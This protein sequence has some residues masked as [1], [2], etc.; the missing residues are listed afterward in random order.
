VLFLIQ[1]NSSNPYTSM[2][3][4]SIVPG[5]L[6]IVNYR[7]R[8]NAKC[9]SVGSKFFFIFWIV[10]ATYLIM[11]KHLLLLFGKYFYNF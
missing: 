8:D 5:H 6:L 3:Q 10:T 4:C 9:S 11:T 2:D 7:R 1:I